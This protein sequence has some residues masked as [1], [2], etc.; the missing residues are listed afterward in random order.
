MA[1]IEID[2]ANQKIKLDSD[3]DTFIEAA[4]D[5]TIK[6]N[7]AGAEDFQI[8]A[9]TL[10]ALSGSTIKTDTIAE[11]TS[12]NGVN[13]DSLII[14]DQKITNH[15]GMVSQ[16]VSVSKLD[17]FNTNSTS[18]TDITGFTASITPSSTDSKI[19]VISNWMWGSSASPYPKFILLRGS[20]SI[21]I[22]NTDTGATRVSVGNNTD[23][24]GDEG[25]ILQEQLGHHFLDSPSSTSEVTYKWQVKSFNSGRVIYV[26]G[27]ASTADSN[28]VAA[29]TNITLMEI[30]G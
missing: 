3:G 26:G 22:G 12:A 25:T 2:G 16:V 17:S 1:S 7:V 10:T 8:T 4:T 19:L 24:A 28:R 9:N 15:V 23:P 21:N 5:D 13:I 27:T 29:P 14:K 6:V 30:L 11:T 20:T 18:Y